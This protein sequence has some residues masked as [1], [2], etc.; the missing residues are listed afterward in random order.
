MGSAIRIQAPELVYHVA[1]R[2]VDKQRIFGV[3]DGDRFVFVALLAKTVERYGLVVHAYCLMGNHFHLVVE[4]PNANLGDAIRYLKSSYALWFNDFRPREGTLFERRY[5]S[6]VIV[7]EAHAFA[8]CR[9]VV[10]NPVRAGL[11]RHP[12][13]WGW[14]SY[15]ATAG[16]SERVAWLETKL[17]HD[18][19]GGGDLGRRRYVQ[20][21]AAALEEPGVVWSRV[22]PL[23]Q[24][25]SRTA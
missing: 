16:I 19:F 3:V 23:G 14:S 13:D 9:Y 24:A 6:E 8:L 5:F 18:I 11:C 15:R 20:F 2:G 7:D 25:T 4:T 1:S 17:I 22:L 10:L 21:V 12:V